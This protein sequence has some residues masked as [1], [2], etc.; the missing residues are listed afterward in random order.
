M[1]KTTTVSLKASSSYRR[2]FAQVALD[3]GRDMGDL[4][5]EALDA[6]FGA[7]IERYTKIFAPS[8]AQKV[9]SN[10]VSVVEAEHA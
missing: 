7:E 8:D 10:P 9:Q 2:A 4:V 5:R 6:H 3:Q 1:R